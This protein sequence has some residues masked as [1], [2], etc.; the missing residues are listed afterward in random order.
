MEWKGI[1]TIIKDGETV[2]SSAYEYSIVKLINDGA[3]IVYKA[4]R[5]DGKEIFLKH[6][7]DPNQQQSEWTEFI[8]FQH[9]VLRIL[10][11]L[12]DV[13]EI[14][15]EFFEYQGYHFHAKSFESY[16]DLSEVIWPENSKNRMSFPDR[17]NLVLVLLNILDKV[18][19]KGIIHSDLK[20]QQFLVEKNSSAEFG[21]NAKIIDFDHC[22][23]PTLNLSRPAGTDGWWS[24]EHVKNSNIGFHS[25]VFTM[26]QIIYSIITGGRQPYGHSLKN[27][28]YDNDILSKTGYKS[29]NEL[30]H[31][32]LPT[33]ISD[34]IDDMMHPDYR[35][36]PTIQDVYTKI[37]SALNKPSKPEV[38]ILESNGK[39]RIIMHTEV[40]TREI[41]KSTFGNHKEIYNK[42]FE[43]MKDNSGDWFI[44]GYDVPGS[45]KDKK[46]NVFTFYKTLYNGNNVTNKY[47]PLEDG[48]LIK[49]GNVE[50]KVRF[51]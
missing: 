34:I 15:Y 31:N 45:A 44:K 47:T 5:N 4:Q 32:A 43:I 51:K 13:A 48:G 20:P 49:V 17:F 14:N 16:Q 46:G 26:G 27:D 18:H 25:D 33:D 29:L 23:I 10:Q 3:S 2:R 41:V 1:S 9:S 40:I 36:R 21:W 22:I 37:Y 38:I 35:K 6:F 24:P 8:K 50:F 30:F 11:Q 19:K 42:Q 12:V 28:T 39:S 7:K